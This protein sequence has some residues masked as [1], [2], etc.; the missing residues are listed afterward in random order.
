MLGAGAVFGK[1]EGGAAGTF[2]FTQRSV[3]ILLQKWS[4]VVRCEGLGARIKPAA[5]NIMIKELCISD[6]HK[7]LLMANSA[8]IEYLV[9]A[10]LLVR[11]SRVQSAFSALRSNARLILVRRI[12][13][14]PEQ[15]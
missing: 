14:T 3:D 13:R 1:D 6:R 8:F 7:P 4:D 5:G 2:A 9:D 10:L 12:R 11:F 15:I